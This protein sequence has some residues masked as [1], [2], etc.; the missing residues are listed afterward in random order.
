MSL[1]NPQNLRQRNDK[2]S[3]SRTWKKSSASTRRSEKGFLAV[4]LPLPRAIH[5]RE[6]RPL[7][8]RTSRTRPGG[9]AKAVE[10]ESIGRSEIRLQLQTSRDISMILPA[11]ASQIHRHIYKSES[12]SREIEATQRSNLHRSSHLAIREGLMQAGEG[13][14]ELA[15]EVHE[16]A[17][18]HG[19]GS[20]SSRP[21]SIPQRG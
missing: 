13:V 21:C 4:R 17:K 16:Q 15:I 1:I 19:A 10:A 8:D 7:L 9:R 12:A 14:S 18:V 2:Q 3:R 5:H 6:V 20:S 11:L